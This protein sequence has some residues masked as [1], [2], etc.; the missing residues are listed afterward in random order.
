MSGARSTHRVSFNR[1]TR[2]NR[3]TGGRVPRVARLLALAHKINGMIEV[4]EIRDLADAARQLGL[5]RAR[6]TQ[7]TNLLLLAPRIQ[8]EVLSMDPIDAGREP[9]SE[10]QLRTVVADPDWTDQYEL[11]RKICE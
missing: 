11:W 7:I 5:T 10:R 4:G 8:E 1:P 3:Q 2:A 6:V 9:V